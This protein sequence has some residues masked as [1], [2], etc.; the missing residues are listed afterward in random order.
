MKALLEELRSGEIQIVDVPPPELGYGGILIETH[1]S[2][3]SSGTELAKLETANKSV[4]QRAMARPDLVRR[5]LAVVREQ[6]VRTAY[7]KVQARLG[8]L[9]PLGYSCSGIVLA[10]SPGVKFQ[11]GDRVACAGVGYANH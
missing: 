3:I 1:F 5:V 8:A 7:Q 6:G 2:A 11:P 9:S 10:A 4:L